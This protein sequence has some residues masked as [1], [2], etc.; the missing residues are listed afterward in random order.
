MINTG[1][2]L[3]RPSE[4]EYAAF[5]RFLV[6]NQFETPAALKTDL[7]A[8]GKSSAVVS[9]QPWLTPR[10][11]QWEQKFC[12]AN[13]L[14]FQSPA[15]VDHRSPLRNCPVCAAQCYHTVLY[16]Y[17]WEKRCPTHQHE[18][19]TVCPSCKQ[20]W[21]QPSELLKRNCPCCSANLSLTYLAENIVSK[22]SMDTRFFEEVGAISQ[23][24]DVQV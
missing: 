21:P 11:R 2:L 20:P 15:P 17:P 18:I 4:S 5:R 23:Q 1:L 9:G 14:P 24:Y 19:V 13:S 7:Q 6:A 3:R 22:D 12:E 16:Q 8:F 10:A